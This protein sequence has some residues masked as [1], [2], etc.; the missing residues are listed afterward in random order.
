MEREILASMAEW[1]KSD[2]RKPL[3]LMGARQV[4]KTWLMEEF[5]RRHYPRDTV[6][7]NFMDN[8]LLREQF[9]S[10]NIDARTVIETIRL[11]TGKKI[12]EG[13]TLLILDEI[14]ESARALTSLKFLCEGAPRLAVMAA[15]SLLGLAL[16]R[17]RKKDKGEDSSDDNSDDSS[18][19]ADSQKGN[20]ASFP[21]GK[22]DF[23]DI[24]PLT[25]RE[26]LLATGNER[27]LEPI[28]ERNYEMI[29][30]Q[31][32][33]LTKLLK[34]YY[35]VGGMPEA[36]KV[37]AET[38]DFGKTRKIQKAILRAYDEDFAKH[39]KNPYLLAKLRL[40]WNNI[41]AQLAK[42]NKKFI[43]K[44]LKTGARAREYEEALQWLKDAGMVHQHYRVDPPR[45]PLRSYEDYSAFKLFMH[46][47]GLLGAMSNLPAKTLLEGSDIFTNFNGSLTEQYVLQELVAADVA[48]NYWTPDSG[49]AEVDF[50][51]QGANEVFPLEAKAGTNTKAK[52]LKTYRETFKPKKSYRVSMA[53]WR[54]DSD[55]E[56]V[57]LYA[58]PSI[59]AEIDDGNSITFDQL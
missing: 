53:G 20:K 21:V 57:P 34:S 58:I 33:A 46:D 14:Q 30:V 50:V 27:Y 7:V 13:K 39:A 3:V 49:D 42:E 12:V 45:M 32:V 31:H 44:S 23:M 24:R 15:G 29:K 35:F 11:A 55:P 48:S 22:V 8:D 5:A 28:D 56:D 6:F 4:G 43:Y 51:I 54:P 19:D 37:F 17:K 2:Y 40:L 26:F 38:G 36:V 41:P 9:T 47:V 52:S 16:N 59:A 18:D 1:E 10:I 25:F